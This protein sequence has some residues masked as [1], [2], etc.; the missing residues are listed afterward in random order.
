MKLKSGQ[1]G[2]TVKSLM[3]AGYTLPDLEIFNDWWKAKD[4][5]GQRDQPPTIQQVVD[6]IYQAKQE[7][8]PPARANENGK[9]LI[10]LSDNTIAEATV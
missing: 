2:K 4:F 8:P 1:I 10:I 9:A 5:R 6:L 7:T 3:G